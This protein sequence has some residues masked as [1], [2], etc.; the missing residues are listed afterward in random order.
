M[1]STDVA[2]WHISRPRRYSESCSEDTR[3][4]G[5]I[6]GHAEPPLQSLEYLKHDS[7]RLEEKRDSFYTK[8][9]QFNCTR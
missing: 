1:T 4:G 2:Q 7:W 3:V 9:G 6:Y 5:R 8:E